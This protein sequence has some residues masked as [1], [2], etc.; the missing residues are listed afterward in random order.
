MFFNFFFKILEKNQIF[1][2]TIEIVDQNILFSIQP[3]VL[4]IVYFWG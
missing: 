1:D 2:F 4:E 3:L